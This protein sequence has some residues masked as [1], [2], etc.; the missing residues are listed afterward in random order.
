MFKFDFKYNKLTYHINDYD[1]VQWCKGCDRS[2]AIIY[3][4]YSD[5]FT[6]Y[7]CGKCEA[8]RFG[9]PIN[10]IKDHYD[11][12]I[13]ILSWLRRDEMP[14][15][16]LKQIFEHNKGKEPTNYVEKTAFEIFNK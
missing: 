9:P 16:I 13:D 2:S 12:V 4:R 8:E 11:T 15:S 5:G 7:R 1:Y 14:K 6:I 10:N 3:I